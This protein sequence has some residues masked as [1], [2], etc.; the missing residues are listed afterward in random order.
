MQ[1]LASK[2]CLD[3]LLN[4]QI[5]GSKTYDNSYIKNLCEHVSSCTHI[6]ENGECQ[7]CKIDTLRIKLAEFYAVMEHT[8]EQKRGN[9]MIF[10]IGHTKTYRHY[11]KY[12]PDKFMKTGKRDDYPGGWVWKTM[13]EARAN[14]PRGYSVYGVEADW[15]K[16]TIPTG[17]NMHNL[18]IDSKLIILKRDRPNVNETK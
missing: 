5:N 7:I 6:L 10:T 16:D 8:I 17:Y 9:K 1:Y 2:L 14:C 12:L 3:I 15:E 11:F 4:R 18:K 13:E